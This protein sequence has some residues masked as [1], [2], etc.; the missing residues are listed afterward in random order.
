MASLLADTAVLKSGRRVEGTYLGGDSRSV[1][2][3]AG[4]RVETIDV[5][6]LRAIEF[7]SGMG[8]GSASS[9]SSRSNSM[10]RSANANTAPAPRGGGFEVPAG[11]RIVVRLIDN[12]DSERDS[13][14]RL[15]KA[16]LDEAIVVDGQTIV[17][18]NGDVTL[19]LVDDKQS[20]KL[21]GRTVLTLDV[22]SLNVNGREVDVQ[23]AEI[24]QQSGSQGARTAKAA[25]GVGAIGAIIG[26]I[27]GGGSGA[28][29]GAA[30]GAAVGAGSQVMLKGQRVRIPSETRLSF[31]LEQPVRI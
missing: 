14:G 24:E 16:S 22:V 11:T 13:V 5:N 20:G 26:G 7:G 18:R 9:M 27:A 17:P 21:A 31:T 23:T 3:A 10:S 1:R 29:I 6:E 2:I 8:T 30:S 28:A 25:A 19:K 12:V 4:D 15:Y